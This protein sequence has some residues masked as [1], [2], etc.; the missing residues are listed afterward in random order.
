MKPY[1]TLQKKRGHQV[2]LSLPV[3]DWVWPQRKKLYSHPKL[4]KS[5]QKNTIVNGTR[6]HKR[7]KRA[8]YFHPAPAKDPKSTTITVYV[9]Y[10]L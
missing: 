2:D 4:P 9:P 5:A 10:L 1:G 6:S 3:N 7:S 8:Y